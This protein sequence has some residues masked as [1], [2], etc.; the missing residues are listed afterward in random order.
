MIQMPAPEAATIG[1][2]Y[3]QGRAIGLWSNPGDL[4]LSPFAGIGSEGHQAL[5]MGRKFIG[6]ELKPQYYELACQ[7]IGDAQK[8]QGGLFAE[9]VA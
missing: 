2:A 6:T 1:R 5:K 8:E 7:N 9:L 3:C 4:V